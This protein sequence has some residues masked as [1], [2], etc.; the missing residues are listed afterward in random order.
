MRVIVLLIVLR[1]AAAFAQPAPEIPDKPFYFGPRVGINT[2]WLAGDDIVKSNFEERIGVYAGGFAMIEFGRFLAL[3]GG[4]AFSQK[5]NAFVSGSLKLDYLQLE[6]I[7]VVHALVGQNV[8]VR[9]LYGAT[10]AYNVRARFVQGAIDNSIRDFTEANDVGL[11]LGVGVE[12]NTSVGKIIVDGR[13]EHGL[14]RVDGDGN[15]EQIRNR[16]FTFCVGFGF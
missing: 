4:L 9:G 5:G 12:S 14:R 7:G 1:S 6:V 13:Y 10:L 2:S 3:E 15:R 8:R 16:L 11:V